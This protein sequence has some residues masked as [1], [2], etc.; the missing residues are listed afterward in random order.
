MLGFLFCAA[1]CAVLW[2]GVPVAG[3]LVLMS[4]FNPAT[5]GGGYLAW[6]V[7]SIFAVLL[8]APPIS[9]VVLFQGYGSFLK[10]WPLLKLISFLL[11]VVLFYMLLFLVYY[12]F[13]KFICEKYLKNRF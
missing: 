4:I 12:G 1:L 8:F 13:R 10:E 11:G 3:F 5:K 7:G 9:L 2:V 6:C